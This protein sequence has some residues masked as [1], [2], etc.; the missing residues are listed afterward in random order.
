MAFLDA[1]QTRLA[2]LIAGAYP[3]SPGPGDRVIPAGTFTMGRVFLPAQNPEW[4]RI[5]LTRQYDLVYREQEYD[6]DDPT[7][8]NQHQGPHVRRVSVD[9][10]VQYALE[11]PTALA[12]RDRELVLGALTTAT[13]HAQND[14]TLLEW[15]LAYPASWA[16]VAIGCTRS[17]RI[18][19]AKVDTLRVALTVPLLILVE[20]NITSSPG[21]WS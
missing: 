7:A 2:A 13:L 8:E 17:G 15:V 20:Q 10:R 3:A 4:P 16:G 19:A 5:A 21:A 11:R 9:V 14:G 18:T 6:A 12:P 1:V